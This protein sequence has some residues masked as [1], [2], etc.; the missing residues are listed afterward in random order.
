MRERERGR[1]REREKMHV[2]QEEK[3]KCII[4]PHTRL[5]NAEE[6]KKKITSFTSQ[7]ANIFVFVIQKKN[8]LKVS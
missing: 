2:Q 6:L 3:V 5:D 1:E 8:L 7:Q 4:Y